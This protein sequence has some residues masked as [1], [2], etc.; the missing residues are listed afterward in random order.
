MSTNL[1]TSCRN[2]MPFYCLS[3]K[4]KGFNTFLKETNKRGNIGVRKDWLKRPTI[5]ASFIR[6]MYQLVSLVFPRFQ[7]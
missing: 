6:K 2:A 1:G 7:L 3:L 5:K 4:K